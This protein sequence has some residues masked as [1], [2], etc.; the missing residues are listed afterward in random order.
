MRLSR[1]P[2]C[3]QITSGIASGGAAGRSALAFSVWVTLQNLTNRLYYEGVR[4]RAGIVPGTP[5]SALV[6]ITYAFF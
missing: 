6:G 1:R 3:G 4:G 2:A 5:R